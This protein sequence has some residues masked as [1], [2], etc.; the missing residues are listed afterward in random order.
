MVV[1]GIP[2]AVVVVAVVVVALVA[3]GGSGDARLARAGNGKA[4]LSQNQKRIAWMR[5]QE[6]D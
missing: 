3:A 1:G 2:V 6:V 5:A 4:L